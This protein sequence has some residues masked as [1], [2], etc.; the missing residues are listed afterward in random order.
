MKTLL[1]CYSLRRTPPSFP[2]RIQFSVSKLILG[3]GVGLLSVSGVFAQNIV[4]FTSPTVDSTNNAWSLGF[5]FQVNSP[6]SV[7][8]LSFYDDAKNGLTQTHDVGLWTAAG[9]LIASTTVPDGTAA[10]LDGFFRVQSV[11]PFILPAGDYVVAAETGDENYTYDPTGFSTIPQVSFLNDLYILSPTL[12]F[13]DS[14]IEGTIGYFGANVHVGNEVPDA[15]S[16]I[17][18]LSM[19]LAGLAAFGRKKLL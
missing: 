5:A 16:S 19:G 15:A 2:S 3:L 13:P 14:N 18:L 4:D 17:M 9:T 8:G 1:P 7:D 6:I 11:T 12:A 10:P